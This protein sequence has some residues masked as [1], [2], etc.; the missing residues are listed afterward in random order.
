MEA[1][2]DEL[3]GLILESS[4]FTA[5][6]NIRL[7]SKRC[8]R[9]ASEF[10]FKDIY[11]ILLPEYLQKW[12]NIANSRLAG[13]VKTCTIYIDA[14]WHY[15]FDS[16]VQLVEALRWDAWLSQREFTQEEVDN[17]PYFV[18]RER[19]FHSSEFYLSKEDIRPMFDRIDHLHDQYRYWKPLHDSHLLSLALDKFSRLQ[20]IFVLRAGS[21][22]DVD[23]AAMPIWSKIREQCHLHPRDLFLIEKPEGSDTRTRSNQD[24]ESD[25]NHSLDTDIYLV[26]TVVHALGC[27]ARTNSPIMRFKNLHYYPEDLRLGSDEEK[28]SNTLAAFGHLTELDIHI[29]APYPNESFAPPD[30]Q[31]FQILNSAKQLRQVSIIGLEPSLRRD[32]HGDAFP[33][34]F[35]ESA[36]F[37]D[38]PHVRKLCLTSVSFPP[39]TL[40]SFLACYTGTLVE[41]RLVDVTVGNVPEFLS[42]LPTRLALE[43][44]WLEDLV[45][46]GSGLPPFA[47]DR[48]SD[49]S[50]STKMIDYILRKR[51]EMPDFATRPYRNG[52]IDE[53]SSLR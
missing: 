21:N 42:Q 40:L 50:F 43:R 46:H 16:Y 41:L 37:P 48:D 33:H 28:W 7:V 25:C 27:R 20:E 19:E 23:V 8:E 31:L 39:K 11:M 52:I 36:L 30:S 9:V 47:R 13:H 35:A 2:T 24:E 10:V 34:L 51:L 18:S 53:K 17:D 3:L 49:E 6:K 4:D 29:M 38:W 45:H 1:L 32:N 15:E 22:R 26:S 12:R 14:F 44:I 5:Q